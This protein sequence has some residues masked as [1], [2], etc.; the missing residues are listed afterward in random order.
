M[1]LVR[2]AR[3]LARTRKPP[4]PNNAATQSLHAP[5]VKAWVIRWLCDITFNW[6]NR[7][8]WSLHSHREAEQPLL[9]LLTL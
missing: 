1:E 3:I 2:Y 5:G 8:E 4:P 9:L 6:V 7:M